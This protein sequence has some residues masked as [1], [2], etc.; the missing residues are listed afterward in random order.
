M[1]DNS[2]HFI[3]VNTFK[4]HDNFKGSSYYYHHLHFTS[5]ETE[6][7]WRDLP[8]KSFVVDLGFESGHSDSRVK[9][10]SYL[11]TQIRT[12]WRVEVSAYTN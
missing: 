12:A 11:K 7:Q 1:C 2:E 10:L 6:A 9:V 4:S 8:C 5:G 3:S